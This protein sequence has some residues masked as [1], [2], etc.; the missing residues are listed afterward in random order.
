MLELKEEQIIKHLKDQGFCACISKIKHSRLHSHS[1][2]EF[3]YIAE[4]E[5]EHSFGGRTEVLGV[6]DYFIVDYGFKHEYKSANGGDVSVINLLFYPD[7]LDRTLSRND[8]FEKV[9]NSYLV[10]FKYR[11]LQYSPTGI[12]FFDEDNEIYNIVQNILREFISQ[13]SGYLE[14]IR[15]LLVQIFINT[16]RKIVKEDIYPTESEVIK[17]IANTVKNNYAKKLNLAIFA[18]QYNYSLSH[19]SK[20]FSD[21]M[22]ISFTEYLQRIRIE[23]ACILLE[24]RDMPINEVA[25]GVGYANMKFFNKIFKKVLGV[26]PREFK[27]ISRSH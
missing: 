12:R 3:S 22:G 16:M 9:V 25:C 7:F 24:G 18:K 20:K 2:L 13:R 27:R 6:G 19:I 11:A 4:G 1:F 5:I 15:C 10:R 8:N 14:Y 17:E 23:H 26:T 21:E